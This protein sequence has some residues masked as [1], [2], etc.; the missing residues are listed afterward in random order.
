MRSPAVRDLAKSGRV[1][2]TGAIYDL[3]SGKVNWLPQAKIED[4]LKGVEASPDKE[5]EA[6]AN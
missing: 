2:V 3:G 5:T 1:L 4:I 6:Y